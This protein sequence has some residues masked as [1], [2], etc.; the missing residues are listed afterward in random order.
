M[1]LPQNGMPSGSHAPLSHTRREGPSNSK[2]RSHEYEATV[3]FISV[4][5][6]NVTV[7]CAGAPGKLHFCAEMKKNSKN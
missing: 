1:H 6:V 4:S 5:S 2:P 3:P 7:L